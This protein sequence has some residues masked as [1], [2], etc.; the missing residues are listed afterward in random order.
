MNIPLPYWYGVVGGVLALFLA[1][2]LLATIAFENQPNLLPYIL[3]RI[4]R[5]GKVFHWIGTVLGISGAVLVAFKY[6][7]AGYVAWIPS[8]LCMLTWA[9]LRKDVKTCIF[10]GRVRDPDDRRDR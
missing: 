1:I 8:N 10:F 9:A 5:A 3:K 6:P 4:G 2:S 7:L